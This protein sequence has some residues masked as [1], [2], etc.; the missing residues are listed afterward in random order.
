M[1]CIHSHARLATM[2]YLLANIFCCANLTGT[3]LPARHLYIICT[4][5]EIFPRIKNGAAPYPAICHPGM[6]YQS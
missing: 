4:E 6:K 1:R 3:L 2:S 5:G